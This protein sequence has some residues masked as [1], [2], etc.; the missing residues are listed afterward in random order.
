MS[1]LRKPLPAFLLAWAVFAAAAFSPWC[2]RRLGL[3]ELLAA[4][5]WLPHALVKTVLALVTLALAIA[6]GAPRAMLGL[7]RPSNPRWRLVL[8]RGAL[9]GALSSVLIALTPAEGMSWMLRDL[10][11]GGIVLWVWVYSSLTEELFV[12]GWFQSFV[13]LDSAPMLSL[14]R[15]K[16]SPLVVASGLLFGSLHL[17][18][19]AKDCDA[20][21][22]TIVVASTT[23]LGVCAALDRQRTGSLGPPLA[24]HV[25]FNVGGLLGGALVAVAT[26]VATGHPPAH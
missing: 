19:L 17:S 21:T 4:H 11:F 9:L 24:T 6:G 10:G 13:K 14:G 8:V 20:W 16:L 12:R 7:V 23:A 5:G 25:A 1:F 26:L 2:L 22:V 18:L 15:L 3:S